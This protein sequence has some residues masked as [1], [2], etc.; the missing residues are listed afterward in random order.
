MDWTCTVRGKAIK[1][2]RVYKNI[3]CLKKLCV[4][5]GH[6]IFNKEAKII[7]WKKREHLQQMVL[8]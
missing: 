7:Q 2:S 8:A 4:T 3:L 5:Y 1:V 6:L